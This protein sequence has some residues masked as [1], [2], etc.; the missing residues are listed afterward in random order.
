[1]TSDLLNKPINLRFNS[2]PMPFFMNIRI[3]QL[4]KV[5][6]SAFQSGR[7]NEKRENQQTFQL[8]SRTYY[9]NV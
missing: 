9:Q 3:N 1:M 8:Q 4:V 5:K 2:P 6:K 7:E